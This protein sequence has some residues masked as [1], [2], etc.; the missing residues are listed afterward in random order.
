MKRFLLAIVLIIFCLGAL[1]VAAKAEEAL[2]VEG[3]TTTE[4]ASTFEELKTAVSDA[5]VDWILPHIEEIAVIISLFGTL[6]YNFRRNKALDRS[7]GTLNNNAVAI[8][9]NSADEM[10]KASGAVVAYQSDI[11]AL[12]MAFKQTAEDKQLLEREI[13]EL[14]NYLKTSSQANVEFANELAELLGLANIPN[15]KKEELGARHIEA[16]KHIIEAEERAEQ[17]AT[18]PNA[19]EVKVDD[20]EK[21]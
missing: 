6:V 18:I 15:Y 21:A 13:V 9:R 16:V 20:G 4:E 11:Q 3:E 7:V 12:L 14:K 10:A 8:A 1:G 2:P 5:I 17:A 19:G